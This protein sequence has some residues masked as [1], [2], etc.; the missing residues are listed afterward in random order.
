MTDFLTPGQRSE[1]MRRISG[2]ENQTTEMKMV[3]VLRSSRIVGWRRHQPLPG[4]P[5]FV[6]RKERLVMFVDGC[7]WHGC[8]RCYKRPSTNSEFWEEKRLR[9]IARDRSVTR[10]LRKQGWSVIRFWEHDLRYPERV[11]RR[12]SVSLERARRRASLRRT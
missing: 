6:F 9:N 7:F 11:A 8:P 5:D 12:V 1:R 4:T 2:R 10:K 3:K